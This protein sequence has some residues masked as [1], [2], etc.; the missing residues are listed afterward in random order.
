MKEGLVV[1]LG[2][3]IGH[4]ALELNRA[5]YR[6]LGVDQS[7]AMIRLARRKAPASKFKAASFLA[8]KP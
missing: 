1:D 8:V 5:G 6:V 7:P 3:G 2:C 4:W